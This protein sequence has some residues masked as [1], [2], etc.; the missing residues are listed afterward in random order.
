MTTELFATSSQTQARVTNFATT[1]KNFNAAGLF[2]YYVGTL[3][4]DGNYF[5]LSDPNGGCVWRISRGNGAVE[6]YVG[7]P[8]DA[9]GP[10][11]KVVTGA[12]L[13]IRAST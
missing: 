3:V 11:M 12:G 10:Q 6:L 8:P 2:L 13:T 1:P 4:S 7:I 5:Y 9:H